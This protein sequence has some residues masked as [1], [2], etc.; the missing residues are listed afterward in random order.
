M[1]TFKLRSLTLKTGL[2]AGGAALALALAAGAAEAAAPSVAQTR[3]PI[4][5][6][7]PTSGAPLQSITVTAPATGNMVVTA[8][9]SVDFAHTSGTQGSY[10]VSLSQTSGDTGGCVP[11]AGS[12][13]AMR[14]YIASAF[15]TTVPGF[16]MHEAYS[17]VRVYPVKIGVTYTFYVNGCEQGL[18]SASLFQPSLTA[19]WVP[20]T[21]H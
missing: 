20:G 9:G 15:P 7:V 11:M 13:S 14:N 6:S 17:I 8:A 16:G 19:L 3:G 4:W 12:D 18:D 2:L 21:L 5:I 10:C 1:N